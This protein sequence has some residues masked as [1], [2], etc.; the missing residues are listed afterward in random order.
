MEHTLAPVDLA[1]LPGAAG[2]SEAERP[3]AGVMH[4][5]EERLNVADVFLPVLH[6]HHRRRGEHSIEFEEV[7]FAVQLLSAGAERE[8]AVSLVEDLA[9]E[10]RV[11]QLGDALGTD[12]REGIRSFDPGHQ[13][14]PR[15]ASLL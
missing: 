8:K 14:V 1:N 13:L 12:R 6:T 3:L 15:D 9:L 4:G 5:D 2:E 7:P 10:H 11:D